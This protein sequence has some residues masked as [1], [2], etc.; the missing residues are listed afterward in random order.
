MRTASASPR[1]RREALLVLLACD[2][3]GRIS[4]ARGSGLRRLANGHDLVGRDV[5]EWARR[6]EWLSES[7]ER[8][9]AGEASQVE[10]D[11]D[12]GCWAV[13]SAPAPG[14]DGAGGG[15]VLTLTDVSELRRAEER[16]DL[17]FETSPVPIILTK[18]DKARVLDMNQSAEEATGWRR[19]ELIGRTA[20]E[21][22][23]YWD[24]AEAKRVAER[25]LATRG[26]VRQMEVR[27]RRKDGSLYLGL[28]SF[29]TIE[30]DGQTCVVTMAQD[31]T[32]HRR[33]EEQLR[34]STKMEAVGQLAGGV[35]HDFNNLLT[36]ILGNA[37]LLLRGA[38]LSRPQA[39]LVEQIHRA[40]Q[41]AAGLTRQLLAFS[42]KQVLKLAVLDPNTVIRGMLPM[43][44]PLVGEDIVLRLELAPDVGWVRSDRTQLEQVLLN[45]AVNAR[46]AMAGSGTLV[47]RT[48]TVPPEALGALP[49]APAD[50]Y[51][52]LEVRDTGKGMTPDVQRRIFEPFFTTKPQ[53]EGTGLGLST[54]YGV[55]RQ[56][57]GAI[58]VESAIDRGATFR[59]FLPRVEPEPVT[60]EAARAR[61]SR[62]S[63]RGKE[64]VLVVE[65][66]V[67]V[68]E[69]VAHTLATHGYRVLVARDGE[70]ADAVARERRG[71]I[72]LLLTDVVMPRVRG[73]EIAGRLRSERPDMRVL[74]MS[75]YA[76]Q[77]P[78]GPEWPSAALLTKPF[79]VAH[80]L[81]EVRA[82]LDRG[83]R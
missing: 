22:S 7:V 69:L 40:S 75:G 51:V 30:L 65:D 33:L 16:F 57:G 12:G 46:D 8:A 15:A 27:F 44:G 67:D 76:D 53:G 71:T 61:P 68:R 29:V 83:A 17:I 54:V 72:D 62:A 21:V 80:L 66:E 39:V 52:M 37:E 49:R 28:T 23:A 63:R 45:L 4:L 38:D 31:I 77:G 35:A 24:K 78:E 74:F 10:G 79:S 6:A 11:L 41:R 36:V 81:H 58:Q 13:L 59:V 47:V 34:Q 55:V 48:S 5:R 25:L 50:A 56:S 64:T 14:P 42:R 43:L 32:E 1:V 70:E 73:P 20:R 3:T 19:D 9:L 18:A 26:R 82:A 2:A 60:D